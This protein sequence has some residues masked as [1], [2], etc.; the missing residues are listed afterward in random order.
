MHIGLDRLKRK[1]LAGGHLLERRCVEDVVHAIHGVF[2]RSQIADIANEKLDLIRHLG[3]S[4]LE[5][6]P[7]VVL[8]LFIA[9]EDADFGDI[10]F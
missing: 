7:H 5:L 9:G 8:F 1:E 3:H 10:G 6:M 2:D 4:G